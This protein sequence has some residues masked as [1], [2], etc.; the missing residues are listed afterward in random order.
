M[1]GEEGGAR[2]WKRG[3]RRGGGG[4]RRHT[5]APTSATQPQ[6]NNTQHIQ[7]NN[8]RPLPHTLY[9]SPK[10]H[11]WWRG[12]VRPGGTYKASRKHIEVRPSGA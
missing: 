1:W 11:T 5:L 3:T 8:G 12:P 9:G 7:A 2:E 4:G 6:R 10:G